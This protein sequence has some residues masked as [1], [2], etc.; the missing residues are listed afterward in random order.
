MSQTEVLF[1]GADHKRSAPSVIFGMIRGKYLRIIFL[2]LLCAAVSAPARPSSV[3]VLFKRAAD[4]E[5]KDSVTAET[6][7]RPLSAP[8]PAEPYFSQVA[9][10][11]NHTD[12]KIRDRGRHLR[13]AAFEIQ[14]TSSAA[15]ILLVSF[16]NAGVLRHNTVRFGHGISMKMENLVFRYPG[17]GVSG[18]VERKLADEYYRSDGSFYELP[19]ASPGQLQDVYRVEFWGSL[20]EDDFRVSRP[21]DFSETMRLKIVTIY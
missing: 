9:G 5:P 15:F 16:D 19:F 12:N 18:V 21:G 8:V 13:F 6:E 11:D 20:N 1:T 3:R 10:S 14:N 4:A 7:V 2:V 17:I